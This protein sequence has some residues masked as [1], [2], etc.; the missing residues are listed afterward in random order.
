MNIA[1]VV[2]NI[3]RFSLHDGPGIRTTVFLKGCSMRCF[4]CHNPEGQYPEPELRYDAERCIACG[5]CVISCPNHAHEMRDGLHVFLRERCQLNGACVETCF[6][7]ALQMEGRSMTVGQVI[8]DILA[9]KA[10]YLS[11]GGGVTLSGG[12][13]ALS[14]DFALEILQQCKKHRLHT[15]VETCGEVPWS[16]LEALLPYTDLIM[17]DIKHLDASRHQFAT[18]Q[19]NERILSNARS[20]AASRI[21]VIFRTPIVPSVNDSEADI[22]MIAGFVRELVAVRS[23]AHQN[24]AGEIR[25]ELLAF[26]KLAAG[27]YQSL[28]LD[29]KA[30]ELEPP[31]KETMALLLDVARHCGIDASMR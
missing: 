31:T 20:L 25:Y 21:P 24:G 5:Q 3:Q 17:M 26:H 7:R 6:S 18:G 11:S 12:E 1:D 19:S 16:S 2:F 30:R 22:R 15:A 8:D 23:L 29:Y 14:K 28:G 4:W 27:K 10:F 13:P 9:D